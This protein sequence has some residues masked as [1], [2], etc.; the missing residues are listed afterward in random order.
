MLTRLQ[1]FQKD[2]SSRFKASFE[3]ICYLSGVD[4]KKVY[5]RDSQSGFSVE[6][7]ASHISTSQ[8]GWNHCPD[9]Q[10]IQKAFK[11]AST[12]AA[13]YAAW[14]KQ[15]SKKETRIYYFGSYEIWGT[16]ENKKVTWK[17]VQSGKTKYTIK[18]TQLEL[19]DTRAEIVFF[20]YLEIKDDR[21]SSK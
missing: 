16:R 9:A 5:Y 13:I 19:S 20:N 7:T 4:L 8:G 11:D 1:T 6:R 2:H 21:Q 3:A 14:C 10:K 17:V 12:D 15:W 18:T